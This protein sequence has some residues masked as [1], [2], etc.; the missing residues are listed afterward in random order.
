MANQHSQF[1][2]H[3]S[4]NQGMFQRMDLNLKQNAPRFDLGPLLFLLF[5]NDLRDQIL[6]SI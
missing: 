3:E 4:W 5:V 1:Q 2:Y 6:T